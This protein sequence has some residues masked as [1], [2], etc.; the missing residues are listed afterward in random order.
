MSIKTNTTS[1]Q[2]LLESVN[3]LPEAENL[4]TEISTQSTLLSEQDAK[5]AE[6]AQV[7]TGKA[8]GNGDTS[9]KTCTVTVESDFFMRHNYGSTILM[10]AYEDNKFVNKEHSIRT[11]PDSSSNSLT[12]DNIIKNS[13]IILVFRNYSMVGYETIELTK[14]NSWLNKDVMYSIYTIN[15]DATTAFLK[16]YDND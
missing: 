13:P 11:C 6:L 5:I 9:I 4:D 8:G 15:K 3:A 16:V 7:L 12:F 14:V 2:D 10:T 1:L